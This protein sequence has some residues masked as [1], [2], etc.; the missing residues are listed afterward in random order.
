[1]DVAIVTGAATGT[2]LAV[3]R[4]LIN[5]GFRV[6]GLGGNYSEISFSHDYFVPTPCDLA[7]MEEVKDR[8][9][10]ILERESDIILVVNNAKVYPAQ[11]FSD[12]IN[13]A[14]YDRVLKINLLCPLALIRLALPSLVKL[15]GYII[16]IAPNTSTSARGGPIGAASAGGLQWMG[17]TLFEELRDHGVRVTTLFPQ[18]NR[19]RAAGSLPIPEDSPQSVIDPA[20]V[21]DAVGQILKHRDGN[22]I[23]EMII[24]PQKTRETEVLPPLLVPYPKHEKPKPED[25]AATTIKMMETRESIRKASDKAERQRIDQAKVKARQEERAKQREANK[26]NAARTSRSKQ[27]KVAKDK[28]SPKTLQNAQSI[29]SVKETDSKGKTVPRS[30]RPESEKV[31][32]EVPAKKRRSRLRR[33]RRVEHSPFAKQEPLEMTK[34]LMKPKPEGKPSA[35]LPGPVAHSEEKMPPVE[36]PVVP[37][38]WI[39]SPSGEADDKQQKTEKAAASRKSQS[40]S[41]S[42]IIKTRRQR[43]RKKPS[44]LTAEESDTT[45]GIQ[46]KRSSGKRQIQE[47]KQETSISKAAISDQPIELSVVEPKENLPDKSS[48]ADSKK[49]TSGKD[50]RKKAVAR[51]T[52]VKRLSARKTGAKKPTA[53]KSVKKTAAKEGVGRK[54]TTRKIAVKKATR[55]STVKKSVR[56]T[57][58]K[59]ATRKRAA[60]KTVRSK[61]DS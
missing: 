60:R 17:E 57:T 43:G 34:S 23:S 49:S 1:M 5:M 9:D 46:D 39:S 30:D 33:G 24:R 25:K 47:S 12:P 31:P 11:N 10:A 7:D 28:G 6:Y 29:E 15:G 52:A 27:R 21:A 37:S 48:V 14:E 35:P 38:A 54:S 18:M 44:V 45:A 3:S 16:N 20:C 55:K 22:L 36:P 41:D 58:A 13:L 2:G 61:E 19:F 51:K 26:K 8:V 42:K 4:K 59:K 53:K 40:K 32:V 50:S 56:K